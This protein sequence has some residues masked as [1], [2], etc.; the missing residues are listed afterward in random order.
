MELE[1]W[2]RLYQALSATAGVKEH[3]YWTITGI[4]LLANCLLILPLSLFLFSYTVWEGRFFITVLAGIGVLIC[5]GW[6]LSQRR[7]LQE[8]EHVSG[9][10]RNIEGQFAGGDFHRS[11]YKLLA[12]EEV[13]IPST[14][15]KC[16]EWHPEVARMGT[17]TRLLP[18]ASISILPVVFLLAWSALAII[19]WVA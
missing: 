7:V 14:S 8:I 9:L 12:G 6:S 5:L 2:L 17:L 3:G 1:E 4:F 15:W 10:L 18:R 16:E 19:S 11:L 13:C